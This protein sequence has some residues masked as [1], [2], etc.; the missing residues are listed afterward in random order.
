MRK[1]NLK[2]NNKIRL[3]SPLSL[4]FSLPLLPSPSLPSLSLVGLITLTNFALIIL[5]GPREIFVPSYSTAYLQVDHNP[6]HTSSYANGY[7]NSTMTASSPNNFTSVEPKANQSTQVFPKP[8]EKKKLTLSGI[9]RP[10]KVTQPILR[11]S[12]E[13]RYRIPQILARLLNLL[14]HSLPSESPFVTKEGR[15]IRAVIGPHPIIR[16]Q[17]RE[18][19]VVEI[20]PHGNVVC[21]PESGRSCSRA[22]EA[23]GG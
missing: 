17:F 5:V 7:S 10:P 13:T 23:V 22:M 2:K 12:H 18:I 11:I 21:G 1:N 14:S 3:L 6:M 9:P 4:I 20:A 8:E 15:E 16:P 19:A